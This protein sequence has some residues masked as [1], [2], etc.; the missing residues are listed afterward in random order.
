MECVG[1][2][3]CMIVKTWSLTGSPVSVVSYRSAI[4]F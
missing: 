1:R 3:G 2:T 4:W